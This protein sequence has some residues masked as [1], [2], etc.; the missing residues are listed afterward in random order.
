M[1]KEQ[2]SGVFEILETNTISVV[3]DKTFP[4]IVELNYPDFNQNVD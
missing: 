3:L 2:G 1:Q 4:T